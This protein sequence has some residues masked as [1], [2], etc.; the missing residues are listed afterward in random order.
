MVARSPG[1]H[2]PVNV[3]DSVMKLQGEDNSEKIPS[4]LFIQE[5]GG[6][7]RATGERRPSSAF[8][9]EYG[10]QG[11]WQSEQE[12]LND[13]RKVIRN[14]VHLMKARLS[15]QQNI[16]LAKV[17]RMAKK[18]EQILY[19][20]ALTKE[21]YVDPSTLKLRLQMVSTSLKTMRR[22]MLR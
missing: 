4:S 12:D 16:G 18:V 15:K 2:K 7:S 8:T 22:S 5:Q 10:I 11:G 1:T 14:M 17:T 20:S 3:V 13:R 9:E 21:E 19:M 6:S